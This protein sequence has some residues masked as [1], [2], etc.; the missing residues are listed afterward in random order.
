VLPTKNVSIKWRTVLQ[1]SEIF[2][3]S[4][5]ICVFVIGHFLAIYRNRGGKDTM[6]FVSN[7]N[8]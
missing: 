5:A 8:V 3:T 4:F 7:L 2:Y 1:S 6:E